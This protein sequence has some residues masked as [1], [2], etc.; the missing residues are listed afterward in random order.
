MEDSETAPIQMAIEQQIEELL[1][2]SITEL[3]TSW[4]RLHQR[5]APPS[6]GPDLLRRSIAY[7][8]QEQ[9]FGG[10][11]SEVRRDLDRLIKALSKDS[12]SKLEL[13]R[14]IK[15]G[16]ILVREWKGQTYRV[17]VK[18]QDFL[19]DGKPY[20]TLSEI[21]RRIT[22]TRWNGPRFFGLRKTPNNPQ[23]ASAQPEF[24]RRQK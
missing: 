22:G 1:H 9:T 21:A 20:S 24:H 23:P 10:L 5:D 19:Y 11:R 16:S 7:K 8:L 4:K 18:D 2:C 3:R 12:K 13:P 6:F 14:R 15:P 17:T